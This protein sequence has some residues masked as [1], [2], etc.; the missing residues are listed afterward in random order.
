[1]HAKHARSAALATET[2][3][4][5]IH[6]KVLSSLVITL[7]TQ[8]KPCRWSAG[9]SLAGL[10]VTPFMLPSAPLLLFRMAGPYAYFTLSFAQSLLHEVAFV[11]CYADSRRQKGLHV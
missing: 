5:Q 4:V 1:M 9:F 8:A 10:L 2:L 6:G 7:S 3:L 11:P